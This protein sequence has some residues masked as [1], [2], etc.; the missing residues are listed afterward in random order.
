MLDTSA[1]P[2]LQLIERVEEGNRNEVWRADLNGQPVSVRQS[3]R[4][5]ASLAWELDLISHL[6][7]LEFDVPTPIASRDGALH[8]SG[9][10]VQRWIEGRP[11][12][13][14][15]DWDLVAADLQRLHGMTAH[16]VQRPGC[17]TSRQLAD[18]RVSVDADLD[19]VPSEV[20]TAFVSIVAD[21]S[22]APTAVIHG[23]V[24]PSN[25]R[26]TPDGGIALL[27][28]DESRVD[29]TWHDLSPLRALS[30]PDQRLAQ[31]LSH[32]WEAV[33]GWVLEPEYARRRFDEL[34]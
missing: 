32:V 28:W 13:T 5:A 2:G 18:Q 34:R 6:A 20:E 23:D 14:D 16:H 7:K 24:G 11:P 9:I 33:N 22:A 26:V 8:D 27:D 17:C 29:L 12:E 4:S 25:L 1:W 10:V 21:C 30:E 15:D 3:R 31:R 19:A